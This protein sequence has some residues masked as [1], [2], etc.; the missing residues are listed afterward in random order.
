MCDTGVLGEKIPDVLIPDQALNKL[1]V[2]YPYL[3]YLE[4][5][6]AGEIFYYPPEK[7]PMKK[8][9][10]DLQKY[11]SP[12]LHLLLQTNGIALKKSWVDFLVQTDVCSTL[13]VSI[14]TVDP[15]AYRV[16]RKGGEIDNLK[17]NLD[18][19]EEQK[20]K[21]G[22]IKPSYRFSVVLSD[23]TFTGLPKL[24]EFVNAYDTSYLYLQ[25][26]Q[27]GGHEWFVNEHNVFKRERETELLRYREILNEI[28]IPSNKE[29]I[30][31]II[32]RILSA[33]PVVES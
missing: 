4:I 22:R 29:D 13:S 33:E 21:H 9:L 31:E 25:L 28:G 17:K 20:A 19:L 30:M 27:K 26:L 6:G 1:I 16:V 7:S 12:K 23:Y 11:A 32:D 3:S 10:L 2:V 24:V 14:D 15:S 8:I 18:Y 5:V